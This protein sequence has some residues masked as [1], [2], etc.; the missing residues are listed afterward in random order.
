MKKSISIFIGLLA[1]TLSV[2]ANG[3]GNKL[4]VVVRNVTSTDGVVSVSLFSAAGDWLNKGEVKSIKIGNKDEVI[5]EFEDV[6]EGTYAVSVIHDENSNG[7]L[8]SNAFGMPTEPYGFSNNARGMFGP[9]S[10]DDSK[11]SVTGDKTI[12]IKVE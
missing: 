7:D 6:P 3:D 2:L 8:D 11:F 12:Q 9:A 5:I 4:T 1:A 10:F